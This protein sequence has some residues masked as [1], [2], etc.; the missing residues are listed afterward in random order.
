MAFP[1][2]KR[3]FPTL[4][5]LLP[6]PD[7]AGGLT[8]SILQIGAYTRGLRG[9]GCYD[10]DPLAVTTAL[11]R[12]SSTVLFQSARQR[13]ALP[14]GDPR[15]PG[16]RCS[17]RYHVR[18]EERRQHTPVPCAPYPVCLSGC[19]LVQIGRRRHS[20]P[21]GCSRSTTRQLMRC[22]GGHCSCT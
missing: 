11:G 20:R 5:L 4:P 21:Q 3:A 1:A 16:L 13:C 2:P 18:R 12:G 7:P 15:E 22:D 9:L 14:Q 8:N 19:R 17:S 10:S 6:P